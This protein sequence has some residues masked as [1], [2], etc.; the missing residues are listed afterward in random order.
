MAGEYRTTF[1]LEQLPEKLAAPIRSG[2]VRIALTNQPIRGCTML[3]HLNEIY[4]A[5]Y[6]E[7]GASV[8]KYV[9]GLRNGSM[10]VVSPSYRSDKVYAPGELFFTT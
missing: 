10:I 5:A 3:S 6:E 2:D 8:K 7:L 9:R 4:A 1:I